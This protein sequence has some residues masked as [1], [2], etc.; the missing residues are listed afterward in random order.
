MIS[1]CQRPRV[2]GCSA[3]P[4]NGSRWPRSPKGIVMAGAWD[5]PSPVQREVSLKERESGSSE[6][7]GR[8]GS[9]GTHGEPQTRGTADVCGRVDGSE[10]LPGYAHEPSGAGS[11]GCEPGSACVPPALPSGGLPAADLRSALAGETQALPG[12]SA[13]PADSPSGRVGRPRRRRRVP[14]PSPPGCPLDHVVQARG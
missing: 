7:D 12:R 5:L 4:A 9:S 14:S 1:S 6:D 3:P 10:P 11:A 13:N 8:A 2:Q